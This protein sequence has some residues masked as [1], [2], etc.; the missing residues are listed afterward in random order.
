MTRTHGALAL[1]L[2]L[3]S[4]PTLGSAAE[5]SRP[6][7]P[8]LPSGVKAVTSV[9]GIDEYGLENGLRVLLFP[10]PTKETVTV[11]ITYLVGSRH[12]GYGETGMAHLLEHL[13]FKG[14]PK[15]PDIPKELT[16]HGCR[17]NGTTWLD[18]TNYFETFPATEENVAWALDLEADRMVNSFVAQ[19]DLDSEMTVVRNEFEMDENDPE[20]VLSER[21]FS[22]AYLWHNYGKPTIGARSDIEN[23][24]IENLQAFYRKYYQPDNAVLIVAGDFASER[25]LTMVANTFGKIPRPTRTLPGNYTIEPAQ[26][27]E[28]SVTLRRVGDTPAVALAY[29]VPAGTHGDF[30]A[31]DVLAYILADTPSGRLHKALVET[32]KATQVGGGSFSLHDP[33]MMFLTADLRREGNVEEVRD[34]MVAVVEGFASTPPTAEEV[35][36]AREYELKEWELTLRNTERVAIRL[37]EWMAMGDWRV[38]FLH[39]DRLEKVTPGDVARVG[40]AYLVRNNR[41][42]GVYVPTAAPERVEI[43]VAPPIASLVGSYEGRGPMAAGEDFQA[44]PENIEGRARRSTLSSGMKLVLLPKATRGRMVNGAVTLHLGDETSLKGLAETGGLTGSLL[45]RGTSKRSRQQIRDE[46]DRLRSRISVGGGAA[47]ASAGIETDREHL[48][49]ALRL[50]AEILRQPSFPAAEFTLVK[51][52]T[53]QD[54]E[55]NKSDPGQ[56]ARVAFG[57][58]MQPWP[59]EDVRYI[60]SPDERL[61]AIGKVD[62]SAVKRFHQDFYGASSG[63][64]VLVGDFDPAEM[65]KLAEELFGSWKSAKPHTRLAAGYQARPPLRLELETPDKEGA[66]FQAGQ[67]IALREDHPDYPALALANFMTGGGFLNSRLA[68]RLRQKEGLSYGARSSFR[69]SPF[70]EDAWFTVNAI[71]APQNA[72]KVEQ[73]VEEELARIMRDGFTAEEVTQAK[74]GLLKARAVSRSLDRELSG[75]LG[76]RAYE[77]RTLAWDAELE[78]KVE[79]LTADA[80]H[81]A[82]KRHLDPA[83]ITKVLAGDFARVRGG[84]DPARAV[85]T[86]E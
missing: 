59:A 72:A 16:A 32:G 8:A 78:K 51:D 23:V 36:R 15:H 45:M 30:A 31:L 41:T 29:H 7:A 26:D 83:K 67:R 18:R 79:A 47:G 68:T 3:A 28:R 57:K 34:E 70:E 56:V 21:M 39:R 2:A 42:S 69:S 25:V 86:M 58:H 5:P 53:L 85:G 60:A 4:L 13:L 24:A 46:I 37:S 48:A 20:G 74:A 61:A 55:S 75:T 19:K 1:L 81:A 50:V 52:E 12:E 33:G 35:S 43:P 40:K 44:T 77:D 82:V 84:S 80:V 76:N 38:M 27:G 49:G 65:E 10:D 62:H 54:V 66:V 71:Y 6:V 14:T 9:E 22:T 64:L 73:A 11:N 17:P 63:E